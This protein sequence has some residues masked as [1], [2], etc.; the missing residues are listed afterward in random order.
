MS[1]IEVFNFMSLKP[2]AF[3]A[4]YLS[5]PFDMQ[6]SYVVEVLDPCIKSHQH[7]QWYANNY[8]VFYYY[9]FTSDT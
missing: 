4:W 8:Y 5:A 9:L 1:Y 3:T 2:I 7:S 6:M